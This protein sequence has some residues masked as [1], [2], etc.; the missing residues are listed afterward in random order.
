MKIVITSLLLL[1]LLVN[2]G[3]PPISA[4][5]TSQTLDSLSQVI[6]RQAASIDSLGIV[7]NRL[8]TPAEVGAPSPSLSEADRA[9]QQMVYAM[10]KSWT[11]LP[12]SKDPNLILRHFM[13]RFIT[14]AIAIKEDNTAEAR[15]YT[16]EAFGSYL[17][18]ITKDKKLSYGFHN[19]DFLDIQTKGDYFNAVYTADIDVKSEGTLIRKLH[20]IVTMT[21]KRDGSEWKAAHYSWV[22]FQYE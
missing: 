3:P 20:A 10:H 19:T 11:D 6:S 8:Q 15:S 14:E 9:I 4:G 21:G 13:P 17:K 18:D 12:G 16:H 5:D 2:C 1:T 7:I 22:E